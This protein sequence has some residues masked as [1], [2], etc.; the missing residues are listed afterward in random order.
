MHQ[1]LIIIL[2]C[3]FSCPFSN[4]HHYFNTKDIESQKEMV[5]TIYSEHDLKNGFTLL[6]GKTGSRNVAI[7]KSQI[8]SKIL[9]EEDANLGRHVL[10][11]LYADFESSFVLSYRFGSNPI[12]VELYKKKSGELFLKGQ[13]PFYKDILNNEI[14]FEGVNE[15]EGKF[16]FYEFE[17]Q[18]STFFDVPK[19]N[20]CLTGACWKILEVTDEEIRVKYQNKQGQDVIGTY[21]RNH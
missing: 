15:N 14:M 13:S 16:I 19:G 20:P 11:Y 9:R 18:K 3:F 4:R 1:C 12:K 7:L 5:D 10:G 21:I 2:F 17:K 8:F 6:F